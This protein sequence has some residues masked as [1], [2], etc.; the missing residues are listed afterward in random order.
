MEEVLLQNKSLNFTFNQRSET[1]FQQV[2]VFSDQTTGAQEIKTLIKLTRRN[3]QN[4][5]RHFFFLSQLHEEKWTYLND[6]PDNAEEKT[7]IR[8]DDSSHSEKV[9]KMSRLCYTSQTSS[10]CCIHRIINPPILSA[11]I[12]TNSTSNPARLEINAAAVVKNAKQG[13]K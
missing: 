6:A 10:S 8:N 4:K 5:K 13:A 3:E 1:L 11:L 12:P 9:A 2:C 7:P